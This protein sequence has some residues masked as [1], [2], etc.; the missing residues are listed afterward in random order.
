MNL[1][2]EKP[3]RAASRTGRPRIGA[4][5]TVLEALAARQLVASTTDRILDRPIDLFL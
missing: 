5:F 1:G 3:D 4:F 2:F